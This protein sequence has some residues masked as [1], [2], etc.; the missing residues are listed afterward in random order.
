MSSSKM[1]LVGGVERTSQFC[2]AA[3]LSPLQRCCPQ[4]GPYVSFPLTLQPSSALHF[5]KHSH[6][7]EKYLV[8]LF[9]DAL[10]LLEKWQ[11]RL[12]DSLLSQGTEKGTVKVGALAVSSESACFLSWEA[13]CLF[14]KPAGVALAPFP[15]IRQVPNAELHLVCCCLC[16]QRFS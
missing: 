15:C 1:L 6:W 10:G 14:P 2:S 16:F 5:Q 9:S 3:W 8:L 11:Q 4:V 7:K 12:R 13:A